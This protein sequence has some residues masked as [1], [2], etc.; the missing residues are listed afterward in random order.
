MNE[1]LDFF[2]KSLVIQQRKAPK[3]MEVAETYTNIASI[4]SKQG[5]VAGAVKYCQLALQIQKRTG[6]DSQTVADTCYNVAMYLK[7]QGE[8]KGALEHH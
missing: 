3:S 2:Q 1:A 6:P 8:Y 4:L 7:E 5:D